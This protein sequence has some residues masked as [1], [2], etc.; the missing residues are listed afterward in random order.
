MDEFDDG[1]DDDY[2]SIPMPTPTPKGA[3][4]IGVTPSANKRPRLD[5]KFGNK[6]DDSTSLLQNLDG[7]PSFA[8]GEDDDALGLDENDEVGDVLQL[9]AI[10][11]AKGG[12]NLFLT[13]KVSNESAYLIS[14]CTKRILIA[15]LLMIDRRLGQERVGPQSGS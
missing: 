11:L 13:G 5:G 10:E 3:G 6:N 15:L 14:I 7:A 8:L 12:H 1:N 4:A 2:M 9:K